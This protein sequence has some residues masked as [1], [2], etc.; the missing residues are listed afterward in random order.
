[1][2]APSKAMGTMARVLVRPPEA[3]RKNDSRR[4]IV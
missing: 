1:M 2:H 3:W 4:R